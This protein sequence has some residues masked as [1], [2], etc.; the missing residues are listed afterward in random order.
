MLVIV[1]ISSWISVKVKFNVS[2][3]MIADFFNPSEMSR[4]IST[5]ALITNFK[6][7]KSFR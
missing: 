1:I 2:A 5:F 4:L 7:T 6:K 3:T